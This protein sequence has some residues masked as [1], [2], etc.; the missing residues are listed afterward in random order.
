MSSD[1]RPTSEEIWQCFSAEEKERI[2]KALI[3]MTHIDTERTSCLR[4]LSK[5]NV[6]WSKTR[7][8]DS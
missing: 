2:A 4:E 1:K 5:R 6:E 3:L 8:N 7:E